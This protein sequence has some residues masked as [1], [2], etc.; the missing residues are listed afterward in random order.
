MKTL[1]VADVHANLAA[2][3]AILEAE[4][5]ADEMLFVGDAVVAGPQPDETLTL[6][7]GLR[8]RFLMGNHDREALDVDCSFREDDPHRRWTQWTHRQ[9]SPRNL[10]FLAGFEGPFAVE[11]QGM[12][13]RFVHG[14]RPRPGSRYV[15]PDSDPETF[16]AL[17]GSFPEV[18]IAFGHTHIQFQR[19][20]DGV[21][22]INPGGAG[23]Q[24]LGQPLACYAV[25][26]GGCIRPEAVAYDVEA[27]CRAMDRV[28]LDDEAFVEAWKACYR[29]GVLP[30]RYGMRDF[31]ALREMGYR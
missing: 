18:C 26:E 1:I 8:G 21:T 6:L 29:E 23:Q 12:V 7:S 15:W 14:D 16:R 24:R 31:A 2:L 28:P 11:R 22:F 19:V 5:D 10:R 9:I 13:V 20:Q 25:W 30:G 4:G 3:E 17:A 27:T